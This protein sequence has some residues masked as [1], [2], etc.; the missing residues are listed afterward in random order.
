MTTK[1]DEPQNPAEDELEAPATG[2]SEPERS[3]APEIPLLET[4]PLPIDFGPGGEPHDEPRRSSIGPEALDH[5][6]QEHA[7]PV[8]F[9]VLFVSTI[10]ALLYVLRGFVGDIVVAFILVGLVKKSYERLTGWLGGRKWVASGLI[11]LGVLVTVVG[12]LVLLGYTV[13]REAVAA[14]GSSADLIAEGMQ[15]LERTRNFANSVGLPVTEQH[16]GSYLRDL[17]AS[18]ESTAV[19]AGGAMLGNVLGLTVHLLTVLVVLFYI[20]VDGERLRE[21]LYR[22]SPLP[23]SEDALLV[24][25]FQRVA[26]GAV[27][28]QGLGSAIQGLLGGISFWAAGFESPFLWG[29]VMAIFAFLPLVGVTSIAVPAGLYLYLRDH[30]TAGLLL[31]AFNVIQGTIIDNIVKTR[32]IGSAMRMHDLLVFLSVLGGIAAFGLIGIVYGPL[33]AMLFM[34]FHDLYDRSYRPRLARRIAKRAR[35]TQPS[36]TPGS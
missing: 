8:F 32:L 30:E 18:L 35:A 24:D 28:G 9:G 29:V 1:S 31:I 27:V 21:F 20:L 15:L 10:V 17:A 2:S 6:D 12:P 14:Y 4:P 3:V 16:F 22:L 19:S 23:D 5:Y 36:G 34:T 26:R 7:A 11:T 33:I 25:T 13:A